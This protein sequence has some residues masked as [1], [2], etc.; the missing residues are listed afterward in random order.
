MLLLDTNVVSELRKIRSGKADENVSRWADTLVTSELFLSTITV[1]ELDV[2]VLLAERR[3]PHQGRILRGWL[4]TLVLPA[5]EGRILTVDMAVARRA[6]KLHVPDPQPIN[7]ALIAATA[8]AHG[9][10]LATRN[11]CDF[12]G[13]GVQLLN[14][15][16]D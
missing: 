7:D 9:M 11:V 10:T 2:G 5:F 16:G 3:D 13:M 4:E 12:K 8:L 1:Q 14:P 15:W 6:A